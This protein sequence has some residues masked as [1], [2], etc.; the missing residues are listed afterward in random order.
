LEN[1]SAHALVTPR[2]LSAHDP[3]RSLGEKTLIW[4]LL[5]P[6]E[7][8]GLPATRG[9]YFLD[10]PNV[11]QAP[12]IE[13]G[14]QI[15]YPL[16]HERREFGLAKLSVFAA[17]GRNG[18]A[19]NPPAFHIPRMLASFERRPPRLLSILGPLSFHQLISGADN[20]NPFGSVRF[21]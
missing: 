6:V 3:G 8:G 7:S 10:T 21:K 2:F 1:G 15:V 20:K 12:A 11:H 13:R 18:R 5:V 17:T 14:L 4:V 19:S 16:A 9:L